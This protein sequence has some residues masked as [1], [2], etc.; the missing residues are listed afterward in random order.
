MGAK[1]EPFLGLDRQGAAL[2]LRAWMYAQETSHPASDFAIEIHRLRQIGVD[3]CE[4]RRLLCKGYL[5]QFYDGTLPSHSARSLQLVETLS[6]TAESCFALT[7]LGAQYAR[8]VLEGTIISVG[9]QQGGNLP[10]GFGGPNKRI[11]RWDA[12]NGEL[13]VGKRIVKQFRVPA[14]AQTEALN[15]LQRAGWPRRIEDP[16]STQAGGDRKRRLRAVIESLNRN[17]QTPLLHFFGDGHGTGLCWQFG[18][19][20]AKRRRLDALRVFTMNGQHTGQMGTPA[21]VKRQLPAYSN[22]FYT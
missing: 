10:R 7:E 16:L 5:Q 9:T 4:L 21:R 8:Q 14:P 12:D 13:R 2:M 17:Q 20:R 6:F 15:A 22:A 3:E 19:P 11:P 18:R 1:R